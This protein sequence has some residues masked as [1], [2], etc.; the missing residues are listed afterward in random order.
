MI[1]AHITSAID[2]HVI[3]ALSWAR[4]AK[5]LVE[6]FDSDSAVAQLRAET[7]MALYALRGLSELGVAE[8]LY[9]AHSTGPGEFDALEAIVSKYQIF[10]DEVLNNT[11]THHSH[12][13]SLIQYN[14]LR[15]AA[16]DTRF[17]VG[18]LA[19]D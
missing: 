18:E 4:K 2:N 7:G 13:W 3:S 17:W 19:D 6:R 9:L 8:T 10:A 15:D 5:S 11:A 16:K 1:P 14:E 12:Q